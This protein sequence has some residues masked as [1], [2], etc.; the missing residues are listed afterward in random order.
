[1]TV[2]EKPRLGDEVVDDEKEEDE[3]GDNDAR[4]GDVVQDAVEL[5]GVRCRIR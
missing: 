1:M 4:R 5:T 3:H 2:P